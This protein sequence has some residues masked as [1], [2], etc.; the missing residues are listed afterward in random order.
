MKSLVPVVKTQIAK[1]NSPR[2][3][4]WQAGLRAGVATIASCLLLLAQAPSIAFIALLIA[5]AWL[6]VDIAEAGAR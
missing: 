2:D 1:A 3:K 6:A 5:I 4:A